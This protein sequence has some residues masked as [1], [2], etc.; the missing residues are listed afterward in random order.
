MKTQILKNIDR[1][2][3]LHSSKVAQ[4]EGSER[5]VEEAEISELIALVI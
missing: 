4:A 1:I 2:Y 3:T 5:G